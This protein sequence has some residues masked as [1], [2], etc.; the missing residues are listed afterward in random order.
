MTIFESHL[1]KLLAMVGHR[2]V[3]RGR[4]VGHRRVVRGR[5]VG[6]GPAGNAVRLATQPE[7]RKRRKRS[8]TVA[9]REIRRYQGKC[10]I[11][12]DPDG[13]ES[14]MIIRDGRKKDA[15]RLII[16]KAS[17]QRLVR[18]IAQQCMKDARMT[19]EALEALQTAAESHLVR[20]FQD[21][22]LSCVNDKR[23]TLLLKDMRLAQLIRGDP[24][25]D[26]EHFG[27][28]VTQWWYRGCFVRGKGGK[29]DD[30]WRKDGVP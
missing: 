21:S 20:V 12:T 19:V 14:K 26:R 10:S 6:P 11:E 13:K 9:L 16:P 2:R 3:D 17:F 18:E 22:N 24:K 27:S 7:G 25:P 23:Q 8:G 15:T 1:S 5:I 28:M 29:A 4:T 30:L